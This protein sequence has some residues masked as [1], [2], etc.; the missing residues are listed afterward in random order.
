MNSAVL[1]LAL[2]LPSLSFSAGTTEHAEEAGA[3]HWGRILDTAL[4]SSAQTGKPVFAL[5]QEIPGCA[6]CRQ[7]GREVMS[8]PLIVEAVET[9]FIP[10]LIHNNKPGRDTEVLQRF[11]EPAWN[12]QVVRFFNAQAQDIISRKDQVWDAGGIAERMVA[13]L[14]EAKRPVPAYLKLL[15]AE[16][17]PRLKQAVLAMY[18]FWTGEMELGRI[19]GVITTEAGFMDGKEVTL[20][21]YDPQLISLPQL[22]AAAEKVECAHAVYVAA[23]ELPAARTMKLKV[24]TISGYRAAPK[25]EQKKQISGTAAEKLTLDPGQATKV[26]AWIRTDPAKALPFLTKS[27]QAQLK[28][29]A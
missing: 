23:A 6:G 7:F 25:S 24:G 16:H 26:N 22:I 18:C 29:G 14:T 2:M 13:A 10:L 4:A 21:R 3:V 19:D 9:E 12:Y 1:A 5:F 15:A 27:Q 8:H 17:S 20:V 28:G 11:G